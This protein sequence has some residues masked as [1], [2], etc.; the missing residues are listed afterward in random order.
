MRK[1]LFYNPA[2]LTERIGEALAHRR[3]LRRLKGTRAQHLRPDQLST[4]ELVALAAKNTP[5]R[6][7]YDLGAN[8]GTWS[9]LAKTLVPQLTIHAFE[10]TPVYQQQFERNVAGLP[11]IQ[12][13]KAGAGAENREAIFHLSGHSSSFLSVTEQHLRMFPGEKTT[14]EITVNMVRLDDYSAQHQLPL[15]ELMKLDVEGYELEVLKGA[16][17]CMRHCHYIILEVSFIERHKGQ[18]L[19]HD[20]AY[21]MAEHGFHVHAFAH[22]MHLAQP[23]Y[24]VDVLFRNI[25]ASHT[26]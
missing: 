13:H 12:L 4:M 8:A 17:N 23:V 24:S 11:D 25:H 5:L 16:T 26:P 7:A 18:P 10:P 22:G 2:L 1:E 15:P 20:V 19:F 14:G 6:T 3:R 21:F 9:I